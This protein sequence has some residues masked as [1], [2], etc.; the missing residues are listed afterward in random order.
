MR[1]AYILKRYPR[2]SE[3]F[4]V[5]ELL[6][7]QAAGLEVDIFALRRPTERQRQP[8]AS[9]VHY[10]VTYLEGSGPSLTVGRPIESREHRQARDIARMVQ[11]RRITHLH[12]HFG[13]SATTVA[14]LVSRMTGIPYSFTAHAKDIY[15]ESVDHT[16]LI[17]KISGANQVVTVSDY[18]VRYLTHLAPASA[19]LIVRIYNG[20]DLTA[21][22]RASMH[23][24]PRT[25]LAVGRLVEKKGFTDLIDACVMLAAQQ[26]TFRCEIIGTGPLESALHQQIATHGLENHIRLLG[27]R[28]R[29]FVLEQMRRASTFVAPC[30]VAGSGDRDGLPTVLLEAMAM[31]VPCISTRVTGIP[32]IVRHEHTGLLVSPGDVRALAESITAVFRQPAG[33]SR[34]AR[35][36]RELIESEFDLAYNGAR[37]RD[38]FHA[39]SCLTST[40]E[41]A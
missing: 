21:I 41:V 19:G 17:A 9:E 26:V 11:T 14:R 16:D 20:L 5:S 25:I 27:A 3:T 29:P 7:H 38:V 28:P 22:P 33:A 10:P 15:H 30:V 37:L 40:A 24:T 35:S 34:R 12:A 4:I 23:R 18:N 31:G 39:S 2:L 32:E 13:T 36:A 6:A 1:V 8:E